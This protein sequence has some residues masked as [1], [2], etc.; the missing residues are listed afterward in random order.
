MRATTPYAAYLQPAPFDADQTGYFFVTPVDTSRRKDEQAQQLEGHCYA[1]LALTAVHEGYPGHHL[2][3]C[4]ANLAGSR[5]RQ[6]ADSPVFAEGWALYCEELMH[7]Q[8][9]YLDA[10]TRL[11]QLKDLLWRACRVVIDVGLHTGKMTFMQAVDYLVEQAMLE[12]VNA[13]I[14]V[15]RYTMTPTQ[16]MSYLVGK[17]QIEA[18]RD[19]ARKQAGASFDL[20]AFHTRLLKSGTIPL[21]L[22]RE[23]LFAPA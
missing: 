18:L 16:P 13:L 5:L 6:L 22:V 2:Q 19:E 15:K 12:R 4:H 10:T 20:A 11:F 1:S 3:L 7:S 17:L 14:E 23:E 21:A 9:Y 8:G